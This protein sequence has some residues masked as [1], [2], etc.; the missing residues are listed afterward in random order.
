MRIL[1]VLLSN[2]FSGAEN[3]VCQIIDLFSGDK[4]YEMAYCSP[5]GQIRNAL[6]E[7][8]IK[9]FPVSRGSLSEL[10]R[11][12]KEYAPDVI[13][14]HDMGASFL[15]ALVCGKKRLISHV[16]NNNFNSRKLSLKS[17]L[18]FY[19]AKK[20][21]H[22]FWVSRSSFEGYYFS[23][24]LKGK[25]SVLY[26]VINV[27]RLFQKSEKDKNV[28]DYDVIYLG[29]LT[30]PKNPERLIHVCNRIVRLYPTVKI[31]IVGD[32]DLGEQTRSLCNE[33]GLDHNVTFLGFVSNPS[34]ILKDARVMIM[35]S[36]W[37]GTPMCA[38]ESLALGTPIVSTPVDGLRDIVFDGENGYLSDDDDVI[39]K[40][41]VEII[42]NDSLYSSLSSCARDKA[43]NY[44]DLALYKA[45][46]DEVYGD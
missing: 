39:A 23:S 37:E 27:E 1:H 13:H 42:E 24:R 21:E 30:D 17:L 9:F 5:D 22:I 7:R 2:Q 45:R 32:G 10:R 28:Y 38:L 34:K 15:A 11:V 36:R 33:L 31:A 6:D 3:V 43:L 40:K 41:I 26:N 20:S 12:I 35:T 16:H 25:S 8:N 19:A 46:I 18:Y 14:A 44:N 29:R 4:S